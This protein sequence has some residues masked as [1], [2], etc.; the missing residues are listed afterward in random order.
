MD[1]IQKVSNQAELDA[2]LASG[3]VPD[4]QGDESTR[5]DITKA[6][7]VRTSGSSSPRVV[8]SDSSSPR[9][10]AYGSSSPRVVAYGSSSPRVETYGSSSPRVV[11]SDS[12]SPRV[13]AYGVAA[14]TTQGKV[15][16]Q[17]K[18][19]TPTLAKIAT[20][21]TWKTAAEWCEWYG[22]EVVDGVATLFKAVEADWKGDHKTDVSYQPGETPSAP[23]WDGGR[24]ECGSGLHL[25]PRPVMALRFCSG[26]THFLACKVRLDDI[27]VHP[28][29]NYPTKCKVS[30]ICAPIVE[31]G[32]DGASL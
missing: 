12:S 8:A 31:V 6:E 4:L 15:D 7:I 27:S 24:A 1:K 22:V 29:G 21:A 19:G 10:E 20:E 32:I 18:G 17:R 26:A 13:E 16:C 3:D 9:V 30:G 11:A 2:A 28:G 5:Y 14:V 23:D 25:S